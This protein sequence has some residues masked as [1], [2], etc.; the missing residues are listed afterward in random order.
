MSDDAPRPV[1][2]ATPDPAKP[3]KRPIWLAS[4]AALITLLSMIGIYARQNHESADLDSPSSP[5]GLLPEE[6]S[7][8]TSLTAVGRVT[9]LPQPCTAWLID[10]G[11][12]VDQPAYAVTAGRCTGLA[13]SSTVLSDQVVRSG[14]VEFNTFAAMTTAKQVQTVSVPIEEVTWA[15]ARGTDLAVLQLGTTYGELAAAGVDPISPVAAPP[16]GTQILVASVPVEGISDDQRHLRGTRC[17]IGAT[18]D[19]AESPW[20]FRAM[21]AS[22]CAGMLEGS[23]GSPAFNTAGEAVGMVTTTTI[24]APA[25][26]QDCT[27][28]RPCEAGSGGLSVRPDT[29]YLVG[30]EGLGSCFVDGTFALGKDCPLEDPDGV[31]SARL[32]A[33]QAQA[34][35]D[36]PVLV[37]SERAEV[38][39]TTGMLGTVDCW[40]DAG[41]S[42][43]PVE[44]GRATVTAPGK[45]GLA[46]VCVGSAEQPTPLFVTISG[47][48]PDP[49]EIELEQVAVEGG[50]QVQ[51]VPD[52]PE[53]ATFTWTS[54]PAGTTDCA[55]AEGYTSF[56]GEPAVLQAADL[57]AT[58]CVIAYD[59][60]GTP[61]APTAF[62]VK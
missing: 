3:K 60:A 51:P 10:A 24:G 48:A 16:E 5:G 7:R 37:E 61:S 1:D 41:W 26:A 15:S 27:L 17:A 57:P 59:D 2:S 34:R 58:V 22:D 11:A 30:V 28:G 46:L 56:T 44:E 39:T 6:Q 38:G 20:M 32:G 12:A 9:G 62:T 35:A 43:T 14:H 19:V 21:Q 55:T 31:V 4:L 52:P 54:G 23:A 33:S 36:L 53:Y 45:Q 40:D 47:T 13:D 18:T 25:D 42:R 8:G 50:V 49:G 29:S